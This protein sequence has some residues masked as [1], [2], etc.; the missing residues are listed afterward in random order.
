[1]KDRSEK[2]LNGPVGEKLIKMAIPMGFGALAVMLFNIVDT[3][4]ISKLS[5]THL[6][7]IAFTFP[8]A[9]ILHALVTGI[10][11][12]ISVN[13][14]QALG[15]NRK[16]LVKRLIIHS[17]FLGIIILI[18][19]SL[20]GF[21]FKEKIFLTMGATPDLIPMILS[22]MTP[23]FFGI[24][25][26]AIPM[27][28]NSVIRATGNTKTPAYIMILSGVVNVIIDPLLIFGIGP[29]P[30]LELLGAILAT[31][32]S[33]LVATIATLYVL[34]HKE[35]LLEF[36]SFYFDKIIDSFKAILHMALPAIGTNLL[37]PLTAT[38]LTKLVSKYGHNAV[39]AYGVA[40]RLQS[41]SLV[42]IL[43][44]ASVMSP[45]IGQ[46][47]GA[48]K[49]KRVIKALHFSKTFSLLWGT[50]IFFIYL[51]LGKYIA[52]IFNKDP[53]VIEII[54][55]YMILT[56]LSYGI[57]GIGRLSNVAFNA[58]KKPLLSS[59]IL[60]IRFFG[61][62]IPFAIL[63]SKYYGLSG[64]FYGVFIANLCYGTIGNFILDRYIKRNLTISD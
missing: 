38:V 48:K 40:T 62:V 7:A 53:T 26:L 37:M 50:G 35:Q 1:M 34:I 63:G 31:L 41:L 20:F 2:I 18:P 46:N 52:M 64:I 22:Y 55:F 56:S 47:I 54:V 5:T 24:F 44:L 3:F 36:S 25:L 21:L 19:L 32:I 10:G 29:F 16:E 42:G 9:I 45:F 59:I 4:Y 15:S 51:T 12:G 60:I 43:A 6:A 14:S 57:F 23:W 13:V 17:L 39:A 28:G 49:F 27:I 61:L 11:M 30:R 8:I 58:M 33:W